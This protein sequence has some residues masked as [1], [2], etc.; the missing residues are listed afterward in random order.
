M[1][2]GQQRLSLQQ[3]RL[4]LEQELLKTEKRNWKRGSKLRS[5]AHSHRDSNISSNTYE[6]Y[7]NSSVQGD[8]QSINSMN[9]QI[10]IVLPASPLAAAAAVEE[11]KSKSKSRSSSSTSSALVVRELREQVAQA[12]S[13]LGQKNEALAK[14]ERETRANNHPRHHSKEL[15]ESL[16]EQLAATQRSLANVLVEKDTIQHERDALE[17][18]AAVAQ[19]QQ[20]RQR[21]PQEEKLERHGSLCSNGTASRCHNCADQQL[22]IQQLQDDLQNMKLAYANAQARSAQQSREWQVTQQNLTESHQSKLEERQ[23]SLIAL[24]QEKEALE[25]ELQQLR[26]EALVED[27]TPRTVSSAYRD[28]RDDY[29]YW[30]DEAERLQQCLDKQNRQLEDWKLLVPRNKILLEQAIAKQ[31]SI[32]TK[33]YHM[34][35]QYKEQ[36]ELVQQLQA[37]NEALV[38]NHKALEQENHQLQEQQPPASSDI[39]AHTNSPM[40]CQME[41]YDPSVLEVVIPLDD[42]NGP[43]RKLVRDGFKFVVEWE[44]TSKT[45]L[46]G[47]YTGWLDLTGNPHGHGT[48]RIEDGSIYDGDWKR[49]LRDGKK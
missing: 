3:E 19:Q 38:Q 37:T 27:S 36:K 10:Q 40:D 7:S 32:Q 42:P 5:S 9:S 1:K 39:L 43:L 30:K 12:H 4:K 45:G 23:Q 41:N 6:Y 22:E 17:G 16:Q 25:S 46:Y 49:G 34:E 33:Y 18:Q 15:L 26:E 13:L 47:M 31:E 21:Q 2:I 28:D 29:K 35:A 44:W 11:E 14:L 48:L 20:R 8:D 24:Q